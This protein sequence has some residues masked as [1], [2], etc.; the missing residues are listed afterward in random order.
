MTTTTDEILPLNPLDWRAGIV[1][2]A[3]RPTPEFQ[4]RWLNQTANNKTLGTAAD[5]NAAALAA[6]AAAQAKINAHTGFGFFAGGLL[7]AGELLGIATFT[8]P[9]KFPSTDFIS[10]VS[11]LTAPTS[12]ATF[13]IKQGV[14]IVGTIVVH[15]DGSTAITWIGGSYTL[16]QAAQLSLY[17]PAIHDPTLASVNGIISGTKQ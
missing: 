12:T 17:A 7:A 1:D 15:T 16:A 13:N 9:V 6:E 14:D 3:G 10:T 4:R 11:V 8:H 2:R 5:A